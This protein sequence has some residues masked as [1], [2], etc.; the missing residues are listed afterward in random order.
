MIYNFSAGPAVLPE[1]VLLQAQAAL[2]D[3]QSSGLSI[4]SLSHRSDAFMA[5]T[6]QAVADVREL[7]ALPDDYDVV[8]L[9][10]GATQHFSMVPYNMSQA[11]DQAMY[12]DS[13]YWAQKAINAAQPM[14]KVDTR[15]LDLTKSFAT[16]FPEDISPYA[17]IHLTPNET[18]DGIAYDMPHID[19]PNV[20]AD[21]SSTLFSRPLDISRFGLIYAGAQKNFGP[22]GLSLA[23]VRHDLLERARVE[24]P[25]LYRYATYVKHHSLYNTPNVFA[26]YVCG[27]VLAWLKEQGGLGVMFTQHQE[28]AA[29]LYKA[30]DDSALFYNDVPHAYRSMMNIVFQCK[31]HHLQPSF[32]KQAEEAGLIGIEGHRSLGGMRVS[33]Y[34]AMPMTGVMQLVAFMRTFEKN[35]CVAK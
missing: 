15:T 35:L 28:K 11:K 8:F 30:I 9:S 22:A 4:L 16:H 3:W 14:L 17:Y 29:L 12:L 23:I 33:V 6:N 21:M 18:I 20:V 34:N 5:L 1:S 10:G 7:L 13:G 26:W 24:T 25:E 2:V 19:H 27:L 32:I 31:D